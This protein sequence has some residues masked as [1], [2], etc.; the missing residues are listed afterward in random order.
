MGRFGDEMMWWRG[1]QSTNIADLFIILRSFIH[2]ECLFLM[3]VPLR[4]VHFSLISSPFT[5]VVP[6]PT[7]KDGQLFQPNRQQECQKGSNRP[8]SR[9]EEHTGQ[10][11]DATHH[12]PDIGFIGDYPTI[13]SRSDRP[14][15]SQPAPRAFR[16]GQFERFGGQNF[17]SSVRLRCQNWWR[18]ELQER[19]TLGSFER[20]A[21]GLVVCTIQSHQARGIHTLELC[22]EIEVNR[23]RTVSY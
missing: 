15:W 21:R 7:S 16:F 3:Y 4:D 1:S 10:L 6:F 17:R 2:F 22:G 14:K 19:W 11:H 13:Q 23:S 8:A 18:P 12:H 9:R 5:W 20:Y